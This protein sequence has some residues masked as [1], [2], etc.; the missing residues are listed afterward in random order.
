[1][2]HRWAL[3]AALS[4]VSGGAGGHAVGLSGPAQDHPRVSAPAGAAHPP[5][6]AATRSLAGALG[7]RGLAGS[8]VMDLTW[9]SGQQGWALAAAPCARGLCPQVARTGDGGRT[10]TQ[11]P[12]PPGVIQDGA[13]AVGCDRVACVSHI[14]FATPKVGYLFGPSLYETRDGG[15]T[16]QRVRSRPVE[17]LEPS[18]GTVVRVVYRH[19]GCPGPCTRTVQEAT[20]GSAAWHTLL[21]IWPGMINGGGSEAVAA[22]V[23]RPG[24]SVIYVPVYGNLAAGAGAQHTVIF[25][26]T[27]GGSSWQRLADPCGG[28]GPAVHDAVAL[29]AATGGFLSALCVPRSGT[30]GEYVLTSA[31]FGTFWSQ[32]RPVPGG[33]RHDLHLIAAASPKRLVVANGGAAGN[34]SF[35]Y[36]LVVSADGGLR[37]VTAISSREQIDPRAPAAAFLGFEGSRV[38]QWVGDARVIWTTRD[39]GLRWRPR[40]F[41]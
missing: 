12:T 18:A 28:A 34:G 33:T 38:G 15:Q 20:A 36:R 39:G 14:R 17:A 22:Q 9:V 16:W 6:A 24:P 27:D 25:R 37:W 10:W 21:H 19:S 7:A 4:L 13:G 1:M 26:S 23:I 5:P 30:G 41:G 8:F 32:P 40:G 2:T 29:A 3:V 35:S 11:L 31:D